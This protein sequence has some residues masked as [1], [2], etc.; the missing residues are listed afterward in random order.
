MV[1]CNKEFVLHICI[2]DST[3]SSSFPTQISKVME[4]FDDRQIQLYKIIINLAL[5]L[6]QV[7]A[8]DWWYI[9]NII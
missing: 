3:M 7:I 4:K 6:K 5:Q 9:I 2:A 8:F 1:L